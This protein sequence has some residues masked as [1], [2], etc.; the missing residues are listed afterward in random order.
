M[1]NRIKVKRTK[2]VTVYREVDV[3]YVHSKVHHDIPATGLWVTFNLTCFVCRERYKGG[4]SVVLGMFV[5]N[6]VRKSGSCHPECVS[7]KTKDDE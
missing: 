3:L 5:E 1:A 4:D 6:G 7:E 2:T